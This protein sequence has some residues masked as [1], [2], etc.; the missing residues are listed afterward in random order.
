MNRSDE[1][2]E[3]NAGSDGTANKN[4]PDRVFK[5]EEE[6]GPEDGEK[7]GKHP[8]GASAGL[9]I[10]K[11]DPAYRPESVGEQSAPRCQGRE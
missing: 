1:D 6:D 3:K 4:H 8:D 11:I 10:L 2:D 7:E 5:F 9:G